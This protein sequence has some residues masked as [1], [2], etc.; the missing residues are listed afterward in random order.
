VALEGGKVEGMVTMVI[1]VD[2]RPFD[3]SLEVDRG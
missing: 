3:F 2:E 1:T